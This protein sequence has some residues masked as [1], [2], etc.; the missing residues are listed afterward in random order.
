MFCFFKQIPLVEINKKTLRLSVYD[1]DRRRVRHSLGHVFVP[2]CDTN[3]AR[4]DTHVIELNDS[5]RVSFGS[6]QIPS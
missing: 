4:R 2:L 1:V 3:L 5:F 6:Y